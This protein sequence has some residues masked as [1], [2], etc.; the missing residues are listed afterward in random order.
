MNEQEKMSV[1]IYL[2]GSPNMDRLIEFEHFARN[3]NSC[4]CFLVGEV[5]QIP[6]TNG[7]QAAGVVIF[8]N[9]TR[10][11][12]ECV[13]GIREHLRYLN[14]PLIVVATHRENDIRSRLLAAGASAVC[15]FDCTN[16][17]ILAEIQAHCDTKP[18]LEDIRK[19]LLGPFTSVIKVTMREMAGIEPMV[20]AVY[21]KTGHKIFGDISAVIGLKSSVD[22]AMVLSFPG[23]SAMAFT[24]LILKDVIDN[25]DGDIVRDCVGEIAN[26]IAG[27]ARG[28]LASTS[29]QF[30]ISTPIIVSGEEHEI[31][32]RPGLP[33]L[34]AVFTS[35][36]GDFALQLCLGK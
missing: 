7:T 31:R 14:V 35:D 33:C 24:K 32:H 2:V 21:Q 1:D 28:I 26:V 13:A 27:Q 3:G 30:A 18:I 15:D 8:E 11:L 20:R 4:F 34:V 12:S 10:G 19:Q 9:G 17:E 25:P 29:Y 23:D 16:E 22:G 6:N 5:T 36:A